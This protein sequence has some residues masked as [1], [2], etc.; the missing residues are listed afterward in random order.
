MPTRDDLIDTLEKISLLLELKGENPFKIRAY[1]QGAEAVSAYAGDIV[2]KADADELAGIPG[3]GEALRQKLHELAHTGRLEFYEN[4]RAEFPE[5]IFELFEISGLGPKKIAALHAELGV[6]DIAE[7]KRA[8]ESGAAAQLPG[9]GEKT[10]AKILEAI[11]FREQHAGSFRMDDAAPLAM[12]ILGWLKTHPAVTRAEVAGSF[13]RGKEIVHDLDFVVATREG[14]A[15]LDD[16]VKQSFVTSVIA[17]GTTKSGIRTPNGCQC[18]VRAVTTA[19]FP[20]ALNYF[21]GNKEHNVAMRARALKRGWS[22]NEYRLE[23]CDA[24][25]HEEADLYRALGLDYVEPELREDRGEIDAAEAGTLPK[26]VELANLRGTFHNHTNASDGRNTLEEMAAAARELGLEYLGIADHSKS[27]F[28]ANGLDEKRLRAQIA[29]IRELNES[30]GGSFRL[31]AGSEVDILKDGSLDFPDELLAELDYGG[32][33]SQRLQPARSRDDQ[34]HHPRHRESARHHARPP[35]RPRPA[36]ARTVCPRHPGGHRCLRR[37]RHPHRTQR[38]SL[39]AGHGLALVAA[40]QG[41]GGVK[42]FPSIRM[43]TRPA[44]SSS[45]G[46]A[47]DRT[48]SWLTKAD[49]VSASRYGEIR[50]D[51]AGTSEPASAGLHTA[52]CQSPPVVLPSSVFQIIK[53]SRRLALPL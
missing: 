53:Q 42:N 6:G 19:E 35:D 48:W 4:L 29:R 40:G 45:S 27:S 10:T 50:G 41:E 26:L 39:A 9:F 18:D 37:H 11:A 30:F 22:L 7:L 20:C 17:H 15:V 36:Q 38:Q 31:F 51:L 43:P 28:Q 34:T 33:R 13:R 1:R 47:S 23:G 46:T 5:G 52:G 12:E 3:L 24:S 8:C 25:L 32:Q 21:T 16:F 2:A 14:A 44:I 49:V